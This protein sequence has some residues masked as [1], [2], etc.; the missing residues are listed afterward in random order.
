MIST[1]Q[2]NSSVN[3]LQVDGIHPHSYPWCELIVFVKQKLNLFVY[4]KFNITWCTLRRRNLN[5][6]VF[7]SV[8]TN[9]AFRNA[10]HSCLQTG[11]IWKR[12]PRVLKRSIS[13]TIIG[14][15]RFEYEYEIE[16]ENDFSIPVCRLHIITTQTHL[17]PWASLST[18][19]CR[20]RTL[21]TL[22]V[23]NWKLALVLILILVVQ[24]EARGGGG[25]TPL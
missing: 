10:L 8:H 19:T 12:Q 14:T 22:L 15:F 3:R 9:G 24:S 6:E 21:E 4:R 1:G 17:I 20:A 18:L 11:G 13:K 25:G 2:L 5:T 16:Y 7:I 23:W